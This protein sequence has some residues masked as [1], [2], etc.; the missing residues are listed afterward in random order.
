MVSAIEELST[1]LM[2]FQW[3]DRNTSQSQE[4]QSVT[5][6]RG[7]VMYGDFKPSIVCSY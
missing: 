4:L 6:Y 1:K 5:T 3:S 7:T 2:L